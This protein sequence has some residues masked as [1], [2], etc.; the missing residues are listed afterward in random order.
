MKF[1]PRLKTAAAATAFFLPLGLAAHAA[2]DDSDFDSVTVEAEV[3]AGIDVQEQGDVDLGQIPL[4]T[5]EFEVRADGEDGGFDGD[6]ASF[7]I[8]DGTSDGGSMPVEWAITV[9]LEDLTP[10]DGQGGTI[11]IRAGDESPFCY[12]DAGSCEI[13]EAGVTGAGSQFTTVLSHDE[14]GGNV[15]TNVGF[16]VDVTDANVGEYSNDTA[17]TLTAEVQLSGS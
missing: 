14:H 17:I 7:L 11:G 5:P 1:S 4:G 16:M 2:A 6:P 9:D 10:D 3:V 15:L 8:T 12:D 13:P